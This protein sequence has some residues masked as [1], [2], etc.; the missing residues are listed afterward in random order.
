MLE[1]YLDVDID[2]DIGKVMKV[3]ALTKKVMILF[4]PKEYEKL[5]L[6]AKLFKKSVGALIRE[7]IERAVLSD[8]EAS[9]KNKME[10][11]KRIVSV[12]EKPVEWEEIEKLI[13]QGHAK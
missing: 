10:A 7:S 12:D 2:I 8:D 6:K 5:E 4:D 1:L 3:M 9:R 11:A 13:A